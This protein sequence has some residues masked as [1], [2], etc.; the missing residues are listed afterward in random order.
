VARVRA[1]CGGEFRRLVVGS[2]E[3]Q[4]IGYN[5]PWTFV[6]VKH[7]FC[8]LLDEDGSAT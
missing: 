8:Q 7:S 4:I 5:F 2:G 1:R 3:R 6:T